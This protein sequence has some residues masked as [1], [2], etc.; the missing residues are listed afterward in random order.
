M[1]RTFFL[2]PALLQTSDD[3]TVDLPDTFRSALLKALDSHSRTQ[4]ACTCKAG[5]QL[6]LYEQ[7]NVRLQLRVRGS[8]QDALRIRARLQAAGALLS[9][10]GRPYS[11]PLTIAFQQWGVVEGDWE[12]WVSA[13]PPDVLA[14]H[15]DAAQVSISL[16]LQYMPPKLFTA[17]GTAF[18]GLS[19]LTVG[20]AGFLWEDFAL[21]APAHLPALRQLTFYDRPYATPSLGQLT[22]LVLQ[23]E[24]HVIYNL[25]NHDLD[26]VRWLSETAPTTTLTRLTISG[27][28]T[29]WVV[30]VLQKHAPCLRELEARSVY[31]EFKG[32]D[33]LAE[34]C[35]WQTLRLR[36][37]QRDGPRCFP[38]QSLA[39][40]PLPA[41]G[42]LEVQAPELSLTFPLTED[43]SHEKVG[44]T[45]LLTLPV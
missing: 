2:G 14:P 37:G 6:L 3:G 36:G 7:D 27:V 30:S 20:A 11:K 22:S 9:A 17:L 1:T 28:I 39:W 44:G 10:S 19:K 34:T 40:L 12:W 15:V 29:P 8:Q 33:S 35:S 4:L 26:E 23:C 24:D 5:L 41:S 25:A 43:I 45:D 31:P 16:Q 18:P 32:V 13:L 42:K 21:P 38:L